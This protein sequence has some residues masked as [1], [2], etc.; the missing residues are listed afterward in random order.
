MTRKRSVPPCV[1]EGMVTRSI[2][3]RASDVVFLKGIVEAHDGVAQVFGEKGGALVLASPTSRAA[4]LDELVRD[5]CI[6]LGAIV[7]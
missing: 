4:E 1:S 2:V 5:L 6:E 3:I 7:S